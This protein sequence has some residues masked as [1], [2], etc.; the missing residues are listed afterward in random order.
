MRETD[1]AQDQGPEVTWTDQT[2]AEFRR[3]RRGRN[4]ALLAILVAFAVL[5]YFVALIRM[6]TG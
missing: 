3:R 1:K 5:V 6:G 2:R 4:W